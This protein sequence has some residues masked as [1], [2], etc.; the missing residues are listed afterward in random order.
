[1]QKH[2]TLLS[3]NKQLDDQVRRSMQRSILK[4][5]EIPSQTARAGPYEEL[6][7][8]LG[9]LLAA[10]RPYRREKNTNII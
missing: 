3:L 9:G 1:M 7:Q 8:N 6:Q 4:G 2:K 10:G 5:K